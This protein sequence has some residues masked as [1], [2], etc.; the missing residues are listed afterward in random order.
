VLLVGVVL[1]AEYGVDPTGIGRVIGLTQMG[2]LKRMLAEEAAEDTAADS[3]AAA[4]KA[5]AGADTSRR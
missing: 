1:P 5:A 3:V 2:Q 4:A